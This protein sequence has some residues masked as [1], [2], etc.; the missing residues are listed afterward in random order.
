MSILLFIANILA[1]GPLQIR[2]PPTTSTIECFIRVVAHGRSWAP[3][4]HTH[5]DTLL[6]PLKCTHPNADALQSKWHNESDWH[7]A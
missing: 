6:Q 7:L 5:T 4:S 1:M 2:I 3:P